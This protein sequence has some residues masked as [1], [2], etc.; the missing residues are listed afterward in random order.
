MAVGMGVNTVSIF[1][2]V[3]ENIYGPY[4]YGPNHAVISKKDLKC[5]PCYK[6]FKHNVCKERPCLKGI[7]PEEVLAAAECLLAKGVKG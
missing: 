7:G 3:D 4:P 6:K 2:P 5:R 1:G